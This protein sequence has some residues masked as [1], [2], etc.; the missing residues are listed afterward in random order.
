MIRNALM[1]AIQQKLVASGPI[2]T[3]IL[4][5][6]G[7]DGTI[8]LDGKASPPTVTDTGLAPDATVSVAASDLQKLMT[9]QLDPMKAYAFGKIK[10]RGDMGAVMKLSSLMR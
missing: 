1:G 8:F 10:I 9:G 3:A 4:F 6:M 7:A 5:D 2:G